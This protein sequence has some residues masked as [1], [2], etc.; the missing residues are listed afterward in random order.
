MSE[1]DSI[2]ELLTLAASGVLDADEERRV[3]RHLAT[4]SGC[5]AE[6]ESWRSLTGALRRLPTPQASA[7]MVERTRA[8]VTCELAARAP[9]TNGNGRHTLAWLVAFT[10]ALTIASCPVITFVCE[11]LFPPLRGD[12]ARLWI[13][14]L[15]FTLMGWMTAG[16]AVVMIG[17]QRRH[18]AVA[19]RMA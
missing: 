4:C 14:L 7:A 12:W 18:V 17:W 13:P 8:Q 1:H 15:S 5:A 19:R 3:Q 2:R 11:R 9:H 10:W 16:A 6:L